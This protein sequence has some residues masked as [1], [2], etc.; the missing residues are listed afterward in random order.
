MDRT[1]SL[2]EDNTLPSA[3]LPNNM[4]TTTQRVDKESVISRLSTSDVSATKIE[5]NDARKKPSNSIRDTMPRSVKDLQR[6]AVAIA[7]FNL[8][9]HEVIISI[10]AFCTLLQSFSSSI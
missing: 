3:K 6:S 7:R 8:V 9:L 1:S 2:K 10:I 5:V 4:K